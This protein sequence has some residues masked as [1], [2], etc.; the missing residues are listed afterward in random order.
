[1]SVSLNPQGHLIELTAVPPQGQEPAAAAPAPDWAALFT[2]AAL[3]MAR[4]TAVDPEW[5]PLV[6]FDAR[7][8]WTGV[9]PDT[10]LPLRIEAPS[11]RGRPVNFQMFGP[12]NK[13]SKTQ[14]V[15]RTDTGGKVIT[16]AFF[17]LS[18]LAYF[19]DGAISA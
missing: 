1:V 9:Y 7:A 12:W 11:W 15:Y 14:P 2:A 5:L 3:D 19:L 10:D 16:G 8:A 4:F 18:A 6:S 13:P 17:I